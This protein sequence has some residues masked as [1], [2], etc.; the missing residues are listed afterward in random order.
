MMMRAHCSSSTIQVIVDF[1]IVKWM[2]CCSSDWN[3]FRK[4]IASQLL[5]YLTT[6]SGIGQTIA[7]P[8]NGGVVYVDWATAEQALRNDASSDVLL[9]MDCDYEPTAEGIANHDDRA[10]DALSP[11]RD[12]QGPRNPITSSLCDCLENLFSKHKSRPLNTNELNSVIA[13]YTSDD[14]YAKVNSSAK[15]QV[16]IGP[17]AA[18]GSSQV[19]SADEAWLTF[20]FVS[21]Q[22]KIIDDQLKRLARHLLIAFKE[23]QIPLSDIH[24]VNYRPGQGAGS[25]D[26]DLLRDEHIAQPTEDSPT[27][28]SWALN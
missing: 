1:C 6:D 10:Y 7:G 14:R 25:I 2:A 19:P 18:H 12:P 26:I 17:V 28:W 11:W 16:E 9:L 5:F 4:C 3:S 21:T 27:D 15:K 20:Q 23:S 13:S 24:M 8:I 22:P